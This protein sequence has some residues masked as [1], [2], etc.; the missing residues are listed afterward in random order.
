VLLSFGFLMIFRHLFPLL[1][2][3]PSTFIFIFSLA[4]FLSR[5]GWRTS[6]FFGGSAAIGAYLLFQILLKIQAPRGIFG[7]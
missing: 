2:F 4:R 1:G 6:L 7:I 5:F 3:A